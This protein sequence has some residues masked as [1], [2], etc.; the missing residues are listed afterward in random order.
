MPIG[1]RTGDIAHPPGVPGLPAT[2]RYPAADPGQLD[3]AGAH[4]WTPAPTVRRMT[5][6][7]QVGSVRGVQAPAAYLEGPPTGAYIIERMFVNVSFASALWVHIGSQPDDGLDDSTFV[8]TMT[9]D[10]PPPGPRYVIAADSQPLRLGPGEWLSLLW[11]AMPGDIAGCFAN[12]QL[13]VL[14]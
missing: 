7:A 8:D 13:R 3:S 9:N 6:R 14:D 2:L 11:A 4:D 10:V 1:G 12:L 5:L